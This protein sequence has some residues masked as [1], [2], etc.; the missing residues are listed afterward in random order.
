MMIL[1]LFKY[2]YTSWGNYI[3][4][5]YNTSK[6]GSSALVREVCGH[7]KYVT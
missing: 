4:T 7:F 3:Q 6:R 5:Y 1:C 2:L